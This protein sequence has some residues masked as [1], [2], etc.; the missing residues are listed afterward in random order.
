MKIAIKMAWIDHLG[1]SQ[2]LLEKRTKNDKDG[3]SLGFSPIVTKNESMNQR[4]IF[5]NSG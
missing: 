5:S 4:M 1:K 2:W 3:L